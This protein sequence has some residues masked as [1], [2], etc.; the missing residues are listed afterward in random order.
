MTSSIGASPSTVRRAPVLP[1]VV[2]DLGEGAELD[3]Q[4]CPNGIRPVV[5]A[6]D[7]LRAIDVAATGYEWPIGVLVV[8]VPGRGTDP[9]SRQATDELVLRDVD[10]QGAIDSPAALR[11]SLVQRR[12]LCRVAREAIQD[13]AALGVVCRQPR[14]QHPDRDVVGHE[15]AALHV[16]PRLETDGRP[17]PNCSPEQVTGRHVGNLKPLC[18]DTRLRPLAGPGS[19]KKDHHRHATAGVIG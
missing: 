10:V 7:E 13:H 14:E 9:A 18:Q 2:D 16:A 11:E 19:P 4:P 5:G 6:L 8:D 12:G 3:G 15:M 1:V 17:V